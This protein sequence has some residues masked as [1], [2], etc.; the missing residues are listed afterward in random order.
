M[1]GSRLGRFDTLSLRQGP[2]VVSTFLDASQVGGKSI[3]RE[4]PGS[5]ATWFYAAPALLLLHLLLLAVIHS[6]PGRLGSV[7]WQ[8]G[9]L[10]LTGATIVA[11][12]I[13][14]VQALRRRLTWT[15]LRVVAYLV[16]VAM[17]Y[18]PLAYRT[19]PSSRDGLPSQVPFRLPLDGLVTVVWGGSTREVNYHVRGAAER[20]AYDLLVKEDGSSFR[21]FGLVV[22]DYYTY[23]L[24]VLAPAGGTVW[25]VVDG[26][27]DTR[28][29]ARSLL[30]GCG[31][32]V[33]LEVAASEFLFIC[34][35]KAGSVIV[36]EGQRV[37][38]GQVVGR[39]GNSGNSTEPHVHVHLQTTPDAFG[40]GIPMYFHD[41]RDDA[42]FVHRGMPTGGPNRRVVEHV[43]RVF[44]D[45]L[46]GPP[47][48][49]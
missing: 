42:R 31:N 47:P 22:S 10:A 35:L 9:P 46:Q 24:P 23:G 27:P 29:G 36:K 32:R 5:S 7:L 18:M 41:Y 37:D 16:L 11:L 34:H 14:L 20:W 30:E 1:P 12:A 25:S 2:D 39:V 19:Y 33:V 21:T 26:E 28:L 15:P 13:G 48:G 40:E 43:D 45:D 38:R 6:R 17:S 44:S 3:V 8:F 4:R 49:G